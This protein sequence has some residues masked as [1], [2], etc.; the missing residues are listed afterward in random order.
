MTF[1]SDEAFVRQ[2][3]RG[4]A[5]DYQFTVKVTGPMYDAFKMLS[6]ELGISMNQH[7]RRMVRAYLAQNLIGYED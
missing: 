5:R 6:D 1:R 2:R 4:E 3:K 7:L